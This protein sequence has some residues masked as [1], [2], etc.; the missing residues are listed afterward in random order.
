MAK[1]RQ[2]GGAL[3]A[4]GHKPNSALILKSPTLPE[5]VRVPYVLQEQLQYMYYCHPTGAASLATKNPPQALVPEQAD[6]DV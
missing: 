2:D 4:G 3:W 1:R 6:L 5:R